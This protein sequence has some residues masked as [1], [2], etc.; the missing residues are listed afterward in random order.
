[1]LQGGPMSAEEALEFGGEP[2]LR[3]I[4]RLRSWDEMAKDPEWDGPRLESYR[5][6]L[7]AHLEAR[8]SEHETA[9]A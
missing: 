3:D 4:L 9:S 6:A 7:L 8:D 2:E 1:V 5:G